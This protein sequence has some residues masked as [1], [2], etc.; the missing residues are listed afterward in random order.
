MS[1]EKFKTDVQNAYRKAI[2]ETN[3]W[4]HYEDHTR[5]IFDGILVFGR[6][7]GVDLVQTVIGSILQEAVH[8]AEAKKHSM[9]LRP[10]KVG[11]AALAG[12]VDTLREMTGLPVREDNG[13]LTIAWAKD[14]PSLYY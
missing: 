8:A 1:P 7:S 10:G 12:M 3:S 11:K 9:T 2:S 13:V 5:R 4:T 14:E 6:E